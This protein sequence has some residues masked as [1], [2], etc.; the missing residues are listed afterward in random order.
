MRTVVII[1][2]SV[3]QLCVGCGAASVGM[4]CDR[5]G[6]LISGG[7]SGG[8]GGDGGGAA[9][10]NG[11]IDSCDDSATSSDALTLVVYAR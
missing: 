2:F 9:M 10:G 4:F 1:L 11:I 7:G 8:G 3:A 6:S 5:C